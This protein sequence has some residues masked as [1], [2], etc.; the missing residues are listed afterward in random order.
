VF[1]VSQHR[2]YIVD[3]EHVLNDEAN[4][5]TPDLSYVEMPIQILDYAEKELRQKKIPLVRV[6]LNH[7]PV[8]DA[9]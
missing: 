2:Q 1:H 3:P 9:S 6:L 8:E 7:H 5:L 4:E